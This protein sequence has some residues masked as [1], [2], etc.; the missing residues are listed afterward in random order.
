MQYVAATESHLART[1]VYLAKSIEKWPRG[2]GLGFGD[3]VGL[4]Y[5]FCTEFMIT[6]SVYLA[7]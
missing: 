5:G 1:N 4:A 6:F 2:L 3:W 7:T